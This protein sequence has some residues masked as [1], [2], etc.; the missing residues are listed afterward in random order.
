MYEMKTRVTYSQVDSDL[1]A[2][3]A[4]IANYFQ[5]C[6]L[7]HSESLGKGLNDVEQR[8][9]A[10]FLS[11]WQIQVIRYPEFGEEITVR[12]WPHAFKGI[13]GHR[14]F[15]ILDADGNRIVQANSIWTF[16]DLQKMQPVKP[17]EEDLAG[18]DL[19]PPLD[20][21]YAPRKIKELSEEYRIRMLAA[22]IPVRPSFLDSNHHVNNGRYVAE[23]MN[24]FP[25]QHVIREMR[26][27]YR[28]S[29]L[30]N[31]MMSPVIYEKGNVRQVALLDEYRKP[32]VIVEVQ[33]EQ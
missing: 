16:M 6:T 25:Y 21:E 7:F 12:T 29:A 18:Y 1:K 2:N 19:E 5:D 3:M 4:S 20:M 28:K 31:D 24:F 23:A 14:N 33:I 13:S 10:W 30:L 22:P 8:K 9:R 17:S 15:D 11:S 32:Y 26:V 27:E